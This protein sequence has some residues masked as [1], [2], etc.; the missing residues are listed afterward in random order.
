MSKRREPNDEV[1]TAGGEGVGTATALVQ[2][3]AARRALAEA[4]G[5]DDVK[6]IRDRAEAIRNYLKQRDGSEEA[7]L[8]ASE[9]KLRAE[10]RLGEL[11]AD[12]VRPGNPQ[13]S[14]GS[15][16]G[17]LPDGITRDNS[18]RWQK[19]AALPEEAFEQYIADG[20]DRGEIT[21]AGGLRLCADVT[22]AAKRAEMAEAAP[23]ETPSSPI[24]TGNFNDV[25]AEVA[26]N[27][28]ALIFTDPP[29]D[30]E[31]LPLYG[32]LAAHAARV[33]VP[34]G[35]LITYAGHYLV[36][37]I[38][39]TVEPALRFWWMLALAKGAPSARLP[40]KWVLV[41]WKPMLW[42]V[43]GGR[44]GSEY[45]T[46]MLK[47]PCPSKDEHDWQ[48]SDVEALYY[49]ERL[50]QPGELVVDPMC[51]SGTTCLAALQLKRRTLGIE[52][53]PVRAAVA[54]ARVQRGVT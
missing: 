4:R 51:G 32:Q 7:M 24:R 44:R 54:R 48:Q 34:G 42:F 13:L 45:V 36:A 18:S 5:I 31:S 40:G 14:N 43:R 39:R 38:I 8:H 6:D 3:D 10:R 47:S 21:T 20:W 11:L 35:S 50:T 1:I 25:L 30:Q 52:I 37:D 29:Y 49:I 41:E 2:I 46:D 28:V 27:S 53:D 23:A 22:R 9:L 26:D 19:I 17:K 33:L 15:T 16:I 12:T